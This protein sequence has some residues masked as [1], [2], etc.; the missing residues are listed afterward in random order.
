MAKNTSYQEALLEDLKAELENILSDISE[1]D[2]ASELQLQFLE[3]VS[4][5]LGGFNISQYHSLL[6]IERYEYNLN[7]AEEFAVK[8]KKSPL[9]SSILLGILATENLN[10]IEKKS[11]GVYY[12]DYRLA[13]LMGQ[14]MANRYSELVQN[15]QESISII[16][17]SC[18]SGILLCSFLEE[19]KDCYAIDTIISNNIYAIDISKHAIRAA[20]LSISSYTANLDVISSLKEHLLLADSLNEKQSLVNLVSPKGFDMIIGNPPWEKLK[21]TRHEFELSNG[22][23]IHYGTLFDKLS[24]DQLNEF[25]QKKLALK[26]YAK[27]TKY[28]KETKGEKD[29]YV[30]FLNLGLDLLKENGEMI[31]LIPAS[32]IRNQQTATLRKAMINNSISMSIKLFDNKARY[33]QIDGRFKFVMLQLRKGTGSK[34]ISFSVNNSKTKDPI[35]IKTKELEKIRPDFSLPEVNTKDEWNL[36]YKISNTFP[37]FGMKNSIWE[38]SYNREIDMTLDKNMFITG[39]QNIRE[40]LIPILEGRMIHQFITGAKAYISGSGRKARWEQSIFNNISNFRSQYYIKEDSLSYSQLEKTKKW[41]VGFCDITGQTNER[42]MLAAYVPPGCI[43]GNK[44]PTIEFIHEEQFPRL[45]ILW[46]A[47]ANSFIFDW[48]IRKVIT[49]NANFFI[50]DSIPIPIVNT[51]N[52]LASKIIELTENI[53]FRQNASYTWETGEIRA[54]IDALIANLYGLNKNELDIILNDFPIVDKLQPKVENELNSNITKDI[55]ALEFLKTKENYET[56][57]KIL[58]DKITLYKKAG[59]IP[60][61]PS[62]FKTQNYDRVRN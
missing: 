18:G 16:D 2:K 42:T 60:F 13:S 51:S 46:L 7:V 19:I 26:K 20:L 29:L 8:I 31:Q 53:I 50:V 54:K 28:I 25:N 41:R 35:E 32:L 62:Q 47:I 44:V 61:V 40:G 49:T 38:H 58:N 6:D 33:F 15:K 52:I 36:F 56:E 30:A 21:L 3:H 17:P 22:N 45:S 5:F 23:T 37:S 39:I 48:L 34:Q 9:P 27:E 55:I 59:A 10:N 57:I 43:C 12:T 1:S 24:Q 4:S 11:K 14:K